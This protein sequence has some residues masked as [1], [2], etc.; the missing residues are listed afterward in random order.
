MFGR[1]KD[2]RRVAARY[3]RYPTVFFSAI[4]FTVSAIFYGYDQ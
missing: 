2:W 4:P 3:D 1:L